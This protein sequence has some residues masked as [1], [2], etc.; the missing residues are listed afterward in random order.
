MKKVACI[1]SKMEVGGAET[2]LMKI[3][4]HLDRSK[5]CMDFIVSTNEPCAYDEEIRKLGGTIYSVTTKE[6]NPI[7]NF[8]E[9]RNIVRK[10]HYK[11]VLKVSEYSI[12]ALDL[13]AAKCGGATNCCMRSTNGGSLESKGKLMMHKVF[14]PCSNRICDTYIAPSSEAARFTFGESVVKGNKVHYLNNGINLSDYI[15]NSE[16]LNTIR[17]SLNIDGRFVV[18]HVGRFSR[19]KNHE[20][21]LEV[22]RNV[23]L[24]KP[25]S[26]LLCVGD[27]ELR[28]SIEQMA[29]KLGIYDSVRFLG[30]RSDV[31]KI[32]G[33]SDVVVFPS[34]YEG[35]PNSIIEAQA[36]GVPCILSD[37]ITRECNIA[38]IVKFLPLDS[39]YQEWADTILR[40]KRGNIMECQ[41]KLTKAGYSLDDVVDNFISLI[42]S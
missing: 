37:T 17:N 42:F 19:Q 40:T 9:I 2:F 35:M 1:I 38:G 10:N 33:I 6:K 15:Y 31:N 4:R 16:E 32:L 5:Y 22:F 39:N 36:A 41:T 26:I 28:P 25:E 27:G 7:S 12:G 11:N 30:I 8:M 23:L 14:I 18:T 21:L 24:K 34:L 20:F 3:F 13:L 29:K